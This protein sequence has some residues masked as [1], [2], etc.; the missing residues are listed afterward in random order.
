MDFIHN[1]IKI[2]T[3]VPDLGNHST[4]NFNNRSAMQPFGM[5]ACF[6]DNYYLSKLFKRYKE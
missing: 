3:S 6:A 1:L 4:Y 2:L 5:K